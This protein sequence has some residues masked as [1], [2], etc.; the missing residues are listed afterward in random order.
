[1]ADEARE[2]IAMEKVEIVEVGPRDGLQNISQF[3]PTDTKVVLIRSLIAAGVKRMEIGSF[4]SSK[5]IPQMADMDDVVRKLGS[6]P[7]LRGIALVPNSRGVL[8]ALEAG[9]SDLIFV[10]SMSDSHNQSNVRRSTADSIED[11]RAMLAEVDPDHKLRLRVGLATSFHCPFEGVMD[12]GAVVE[13]IAKIAD[14]RAGLELCL[15]DTTGMALP[16]QVK[17][18][19]RRCMDTF[20]GRAT[21]C[22]HGH[23]TAGFG[24]AN[25]LAGWEEGLRSFDGA[26]GGLGGCPFAPGATGNIATED[27]VMLFERMGVDTG[28]DIDRLL[29]SARMAAALPGA[30]SGGH[31]RSIPRVRLMGDGLPRERTRSS[32]SSLVG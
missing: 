13:T 22:F 17:S 20:K 27:L 29:K 28:I 12:E 25:V 30:V 2:E 19:T 3:V 5:A 9:I 14:L 1:V 24:I 10:I 31:A 18:L 7:G 6:T 4:V 23:D 8:R 16:R 32:R 21:W 15:A 26:A 11:L